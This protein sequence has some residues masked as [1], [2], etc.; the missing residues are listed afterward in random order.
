MST[1]PQ[2]IYDSAIDLIDQRDED[3]NINISDN[4]IYKNK[5]LNII[6]MGQRELYKLGDLYKTF[7]ISNTPIANMFGM[8]AGFDIIPF[9]GTADLPIECPGSAKAYYTEVDTPCTIYIEDY[10][11]A[12][13]TLATIVVPDTVTSFT[14]YKGIITPTS[15]ATKSRIRYSSIY[16]GRTINR[17]L[18][19]YSFP[20]DRIPDYRPWIKKVIPDD[21][22]TIDQ[23]I[24]EYPDRQYTKD[25]AYKWE[26]RKDMYM[27]Y[28]Y[29][30]NVRVI[31]RPV[32]IKVTSFTQ[33]LEI[34]DVTAMLL[35]YYLA[36]KLIIHDNIEISKYFET[37]YNQ[38]KL[39]TMVKGPMSETAIVDVYGGVGG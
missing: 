6:N 39:E 28:Y 36:Q 2:E 38:L 19:S 13:N 9:T 15:G 16:Y 30:G 31:Y 27:N 3:G 14:S 32:P 34:D 24:N 7:E 20:V 4:D 26:G 12:W 21:F 35:S 25:S 8:N 11:G 10:T 17:A 1:T 37:K 22:K 29:V 33:T 23:I 18:F 5:A